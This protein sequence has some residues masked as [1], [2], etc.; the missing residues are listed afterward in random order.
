MK[1]E[2]QSCVDPDQWTL[3]FNPILIGFAK[4]GHWGHG[5]LGICMYVCMHV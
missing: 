5:M 1:H 3:G 4:S 2:A